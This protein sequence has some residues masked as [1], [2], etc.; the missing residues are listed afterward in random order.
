MK[1]DPESEVSVTLG[2]VLGWLCSNPI[3]NEDT[4]YAVLMDLVEDRFIYSGQ[5]PTTV[6]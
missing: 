2:T 6:S 4:H 3:V 5:F 1:E